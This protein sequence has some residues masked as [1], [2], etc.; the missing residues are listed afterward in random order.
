MTEYRQLAAAAMAKACGYDPYFPAKSDVMISAWAEAL[1]DGGI[2]EL[3]D[4]LMAVRVMYRNWGDPGWRPTPRVLVTT[5]KECR[6]MR[7]QRIRDEDERRLAI[8]AVP[9]YTYQEFKER[10]PEVAFP[11]LGKDIPE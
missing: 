11:K 8:E 5:A 4:V 6:N 1:E 7:L 10:H 9:K 2:T 3:A